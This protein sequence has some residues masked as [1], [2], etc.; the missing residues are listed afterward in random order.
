MPPYKEHTW[1]EVC[2]GPSF[3]NHN[4]E[5]DS[6]YGADVSTHPDY[7]RLGIATAIY[8]ARK[9]LTIKLNLRRIIA[10]GR[11][12]NYCKYAEDL[13]PMEYVK[14]VLN[15]KIKEPV[16]C[17]QIKNGFEFKKI[18]PNYLNDSR[19]QNY[20]TFIEWKNPHYVRE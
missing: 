2:G 20:A 17:F 10:G 7:R 13:S 15:G 14:I 11:L 3:K 4:P 6:L 18:L 8:N 16:H 1:I 5:G 19:S 9:K 12:F